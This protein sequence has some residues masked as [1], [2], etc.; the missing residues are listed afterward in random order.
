MRQFPLSIEDAHKESHALMCLYDLALYHLSMETSGCWIPYVSYLVISQ[1]YHPY[2]DQY[3]Y[4]FYTILTNSCQGTRALTA[5]AQEIAFT[6][7]MIDEARILIRQ[8]YGVYIEVFPLRT[9]P[10]STFFRFSIIFLVQI[11]LSIKLTNIP[12]KG[13]LHE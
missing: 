2:H 1:L 9:H 7:F 5:I 12:L 4:E 3:Y 13:S 8:Q 11:P 10:G 6:F